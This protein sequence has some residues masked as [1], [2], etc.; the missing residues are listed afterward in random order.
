MMA[1]AQ[2]SVVAVMVSTL[3]IAGWRK[4]GMAPIMSGLV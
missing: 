1:E 3:L 4:A 2:V